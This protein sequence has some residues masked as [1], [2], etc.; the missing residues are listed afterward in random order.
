M[1]FQLA[2]VWVATFPNEFTRSQSVVESLTPK[3]TPKL[4]R[5]L[6]G[7]QDQLEPTAPVRLTELIE[8]TEPPNVGSG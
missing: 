2:N 4:D 1:R 7:T 5:A 8:A 3:L 6:S